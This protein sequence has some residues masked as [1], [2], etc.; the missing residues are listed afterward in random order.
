MIPPLLSQ[1]DFVILQYQRSQS[2]LLSSLVYMLQA[3]ERSISFVEWYLALPAL[4]KGSL[5][6]R[7]SVTRSQSPDFL[8]TPPEMATILRH[9]VW[10]RNVGRILHNS[11]HISLNMWGMPPFHWKANIMTN[12]SSDEREEKQFGNWEISHTE[13]LLW[14]KLQRRL[15]P[16]C[17]NN[18]S[19]CWWTYKIFLN[20]CVMLLRLGWIEYL[21]RIIMIEDGISLYYNH[22]NT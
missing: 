7:I 11:L 5:D 16:I 9:W 8:T 12:Y 2:W 1:W 4:Q 18:L 14:S 22:D 17:I 10:E 20:I 13:D 21:L 15:T 19:S 3:Q 6:I